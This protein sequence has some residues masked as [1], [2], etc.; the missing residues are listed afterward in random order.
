MTRGGIDTVFHVVSMKFHQNMQV[1]AT[2]CA[3]RRLE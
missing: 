1:Q 3:G 2:V